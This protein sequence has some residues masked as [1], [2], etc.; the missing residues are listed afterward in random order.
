[1]EWP[2]LSVRSSQVRIFYSIKS[3]FFHNS[4]NSFWFT[5]NFIIMSYAKMIFQKIGTSIDPNQSAYVMAISMTF[6]A[7]AT[8]Y[9]SD[10]LGRKWTNLL[11]FS[12]S[13]AGLFTTAG[14]YYINLYHYDLSS[15]QFV[16]VVAL[17]FV[18]FI[19]S[20]GVV[21]LVFICTIEL[22]PKNVKSS[23]IK[24]YKVHPIHIYFLTDSNGWPD[25]YEHYAQFRY[26]S[27][28]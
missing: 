8:T 11:S 1:M 16:P 23:N 2:W 10:T 26:F 5:A 21:P 9:L 3:Y 12:G 20:A 4:Q 7:L 13:A 25:N 15:F 14:Y 6:G 24:L 17:A 28:C 19:S 22:M 27:I 18:I